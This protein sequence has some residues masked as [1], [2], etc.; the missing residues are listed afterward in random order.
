MATQE[1]RK[2]KTGL[3]LILQTHT[4]MIGIPRSKTMAEIQALQII[5]LEPIIILLTRTMHQIMAILQTTM[6]SQAVI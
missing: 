3:D 4:T 5:S 6:D 2:T 1:H